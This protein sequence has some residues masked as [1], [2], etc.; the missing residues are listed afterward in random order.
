MS[1]KVKIK[2]TKSKD[3]RNFA[4]TGAWGG[5]TAT[6][7]ITV[8]LFIERSEAP[9]YIDLE[10]DA[11]SSRETNRGEEFIIRESQTG[12]V[13]RP[14]IAYTIGD[15]LIKTAMAAGVKPVGNSENETPG[16]GTLQ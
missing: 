7:E 5:V 1:R 12:L 6:G 9:E 14:D 10:I 13:L 11:H 15:W 2:F 16:S 4:V 8:D 3:Y